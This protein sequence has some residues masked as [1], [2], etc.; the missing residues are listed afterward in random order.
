MRGSLDN[1]LKTRLKK[2]II[3]ECEL[4]LDIDDIDDDSPLFGSRSPVGLDSIDGFQMAIA[5]QNTYGIK[6]TDSKQMG[7]VMKSINTFADFLQPA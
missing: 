1:D 4:S 2:F 7:R 6:I 5:I 3:T